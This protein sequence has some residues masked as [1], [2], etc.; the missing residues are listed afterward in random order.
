MRGL[1]QAGIP[2]GQGAEMLGLPVDAP[3]VQGALALSAYRATHE[4]RDINPADWE[5]NN[6]AIQSA[7]MSE[8][9]GEPSDEDS[10]AESYRVYVEEHPHKRVDIRD[11]ETLE[12][13]LL[14]LA[15]RREEDVDTE[16]FSL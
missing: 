9:V 16:A 2:G 13:I 6:A 7:A 8:W 15:K 11:D 4:L 1:E 5:Q 10:L 3:E 14:A 12:E